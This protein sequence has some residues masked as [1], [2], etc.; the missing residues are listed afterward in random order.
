[1]MHDARAK[2]ARPT[3]ARENGAELTGWR[4]KLLTPIAAFVRHPA[5]TAVLGGLA[6]FLIPIIVHAF[7]PGV[8]SNSAVVR[9]MNIDVA[10]ALHHDG[11]I[12]SRAFVPTGVVMDAGC[13]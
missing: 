7:T 3:S 8:P 10:A 4:H 5:V 12:A 9:L 13:T 6:V 11:S 1:M 2:P